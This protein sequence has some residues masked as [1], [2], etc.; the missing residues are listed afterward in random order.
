MKFQH[1]FA[2]VVG[3]FSILSHSAFAQTA[4][5]PTGNAA[6]ATYTLPASYYQTQPTATNAT[7]VTQAAQAVSPTP[8][9]TTTATTAVTVTTPEE[10]DK[11]AKKLKKQQDKAAEEQAKLDAE[12]AKEDE[13]AA[14]KAAK[15][16]AK[17]AKAQSVAATAAPVAATP[18]PV[19]VAP[20]PVAAVAAPAVTT[21][22]VTSTVAAAPAAAPAADDKAGTAGYDGGF[23]IKSKDGDFS[24]TFNGRIQ[25]R[26]AFDI[27]DELTNVATFEIRR[28]YV[29]LTGT[30]FSP[31][32]S[33][34]YIMFGA[35][36]SVIVATASMVYTFSDYFA[37]N[38][39]LDIYPFGH[40]QNES[41]G[42]TLFPEAS[43]ETLRFG[44]DNTPGFWFNGA[45]NKFYYV[46]GM[47][48]A[49][50]TDADKGNSSLNF[51]NEFA[52]GFQA[53]YNILG[54]YGG[55]ETDL[56]DSQKPNLVVETSGAYFNKELGTQSRVILGQ[57]FSGLKW[58]GFSVLGEFTS[59]LIDPDQFTRQQIDMGY[60]LQAGYFIIPKKLEIGLGTSAL[61]DDTNGV[62]VNQNTS[63]G[64]IGHLKGADPSIASAYGAGDSDNEYEYCVGLNYYFKGNNLKI[65][66]EYIYLIDGRPGPDELISNIGVIQAQ[67][68][69]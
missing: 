24:L 43:L 49:G 22:T 40:S 59:R 52:Y 58:H 15:E 51:N 14:K 4:F 64:N 54:N 50:D 45:I 61:L 20:A 60:M 7:A 23:Y 17:Q 69:F 28:V 38:M 8:P 53:G 66:A 1:R 10:D 31:K 11:A 36:D 41:S 47:M 16:E 29:A 55:G 18:A 25:P 65:Q 62:G 13:K 39:G 3:I 33:Y 2:F 26:F 21:T 32:L 9:T 5:T 34:N 42:K 63:V 27:V 37:L 35:G 46:I 57:L 68:G 19:A 48:N 6:D 67:A 44:P 30:I 56:N 12:K